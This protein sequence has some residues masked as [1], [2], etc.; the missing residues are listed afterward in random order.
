MIVKIVREISWVLF[1]SNVTRNC[2][3]R[4]FSPILSWTPPNNVL[5]MFLT[6]V[7]SSEIPQG[8]FQ[9]DAPICDVS[10]THQ[11]SGADSFETHHLWVL[12]VLQERSLWLQQPR[13][14]L[15]WGWWRN[16]QCSAFSSKQASQCRAAPGKVRACL[17][18]LQ[19]DT[20][21][22]AQHLASSYLV[23]EFG[24]GMLCLLIAILTDK[25]YCP[26]V[27]ECGLSPIVLPSHCTSESVPC[28]KMDVTW[29]LGFLSQANMGLWVAHQTS[30]K[31]LSSGFF[32]HQNIFLIFYIPSMWLP[33]S[34]EKHFKLF[35][36]LYFFLFPLI[37]VRIFV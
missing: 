33:I 24:A 5:T 4:F 31:W 25:F 13:D 26:I 27:I 30:L 23:P 17:L 37:W 18:L 34:Q 22:P 16:H 15:N 12:T 35:R 28:G 1:L 10:P 20:Q 8:L 2:F 14:G 11:Q 3:W 7:S 29:L 19:A 36:W 21:Q 6:L 9:R 32:F